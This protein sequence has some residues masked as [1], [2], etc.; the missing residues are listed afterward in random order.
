MAFIANKPVRFDQ[1]YRVGEVIPQEVIEPKM[2]RK[3]I[4]MGKIIEIDL[5]AKNE[6]DIPASGEPGEM[7]T[8]HLDAD[9]LMDWK[10]GELEKLAAQPPSPE[11][12]R[13]Q[14]LA[15]RIM[16]Q[17]EGLALQDPEGY[18]E[19]K[20]WVKQ[21]ARR[22]RESVDEGNSPRMTRW[23]EEIARLPGF[24]EEWDSS[25]Y[26]RECV[27]GWFIHAFYLRP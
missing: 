3:L 25:Q 22:W 5:P 24:A 21:K 27:F 12:A 26:L 17:I 20:L 9:T 6:S 4:E 16:P 8:G 2:V 10:N 18:E 1:D 7:L 11:L 14:R 15:E 19:M 23:R 13:W